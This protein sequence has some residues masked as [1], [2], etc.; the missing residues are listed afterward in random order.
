MIACIGG[1]HI[2]RRGLLRAPS[3]PGSSNPATVRSDFGGV[4][5]NVA[6]NLARLGCSVRLVSRVGD[7]E[8]GRQV[9][10]HLEAAGIEP[11]LTT[12]P[13]HPTASYTAILEPTGDLVIGLADMDIY[14]ELAPALIEPSLPRLRECDLWFIDTNLPSDTIAWLL[15][16]A[17]PIPVAVDAISVAKSQR[18]VPLLPRIPLLFCNAAQ[19]VVLSKARASDGLPGALAAV[20]SDG[21]RGVAVSQGGEVHTMR[22]LPAKP[23][24]VTGAGDALAAGTLYGLSRGEPL[25]D[26]IRWGLA[27]AAVTVESEFAA[28]PD[29]TRQLL[30]SRLA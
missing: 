11:L 20:V 9:R 12:S 16:A 15:D 23:R 13:N 28:V 6:H 3:V 27:A 1:A 24:D 17:G 19:A 26:A 18:L 7:D 4:A 22:T 29:L 8:T 25:L 21:D 10:T 5:H 30:E 14:D 2:D